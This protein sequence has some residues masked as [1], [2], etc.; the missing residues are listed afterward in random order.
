MSLKR[1]SI[2]SAAMAT[3]VALTAC[4][5]QNAASEDSEPA[6]LDSEA[7]RFSYAVGVDLGQSLGMVRDDVDLDALKRGLDDAFADAD[8][9][10]DD[11][12]REEAKL[13]VAQRLQ[14]QQQEEL[15][16][17]GDEAAEKGETFRGENAARDGVTV[18]ESGLQIEFLEEA[19]GD[20]PSEEDTVTVHYRG[21]LIDGTE[22]DSSYERGEP[23]T[24][25]LRNVISGWTEAL[26]LMPV[27]SKARLVIP[28]ELAY[29]EQ[30]AGDRIGPNET[31]VFEVELLEIQE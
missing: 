27:G 30:G 25:P 19:D 31:L 8:L 7:A 3:A 23:A 4:E 10:L 6:A 24:F 29:G 12:E 13:A 2:L 20:M 5:Q 14:E 28:S 9:A 26:Q 21:T 17:R 18:T 16:A 11:A 22:F 1:L 15:A